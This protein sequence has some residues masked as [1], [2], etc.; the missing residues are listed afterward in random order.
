MQPSTVMAIEDRRAVGRPLL[1]GLERRS[2]NAGLSDNAVERASPEFVMERNGDSCAAL[3]ASLLHDD[4]AT[5]LT[6]PLESVLFEDATNC[7][8]RERAEPTQP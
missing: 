5:A 2:C 1:I 6:D 4:M 3:R 7:F 8:T